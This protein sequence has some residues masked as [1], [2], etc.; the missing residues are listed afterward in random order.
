MIIL[1][2]EQGSLEWHQARLGIPTASRFS[3]IITPAGA[4]SKSAEGYMKELAGEWLMGKPDPDENFESY[5]MKRGKTLEPEARALYSLMTDYPV[6][7]AGF[8]YKD[9][10]R[11]VGCSP[12]GLVRDDG[13]WENKTPKMTTHV[14]YLL[15]GVMP[16]LYRPQVQGSMWVTGRK[17]WDFMSFHPDTE[18]LI[19]RVKRDEDYIAKLE[20][21]MKSFLIDLTMMKKKLEIY[22]L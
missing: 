8:I 3:D 17:W 21:L 10:L 18:P 7:E 6:C 20:A 13:G 4:K 16:G 1:E 22:K 2:A 11:Q 12:D 14:G 5:W 19:V 9:A 15:G